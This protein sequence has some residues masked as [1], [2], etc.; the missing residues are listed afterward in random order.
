VSS[1]NVI[2][3]FDAVDISIQSAEEPPEA[4]VEDLVEFVRQGESLPE[5]AVLALLDEIRKLRKLLGGM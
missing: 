5:E 3:W 2:H 4:P 1:Y